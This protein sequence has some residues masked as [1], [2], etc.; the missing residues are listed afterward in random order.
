ME[1]TT[2]PIQIYPLKHAQVDE[3]VQIVDD[4]PLYQSY[5]F[6]GVQAKQSLS[7]ALK[8]DQS[9]LLTAESDGQL[10]GYIWFIK[11]AAFARSGYIKQVA[12][13]ET[14]QQMGVGKQL[15]RSIEELYLKP[16]GVLL[17]VETKNIRAKRFYEKLGY[18]EVG[19]IRDYVQPGK[20]E[21]IF[22]KSGILY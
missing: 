5:G 14:H 8:D 19:L 12:I 9:V 7:F 6:N 3:C 17:L 11:K 21:C 2:L 4:L 10:M 13:R 18:R 20:D 1:P 16:N 15:I 22:Y